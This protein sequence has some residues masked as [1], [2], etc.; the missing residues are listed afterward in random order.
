M[1]GAGRV[2][3]G[4]LQARDLIPDLERQLELGSRLVGAIAKGELRI[5][6]TT[7]TRGP[8][9]LESTRAASPPPSP[10]AWPSARAWSSLPGC[11]MAKLPVAP[12]SLAMVAVSAS[13]SP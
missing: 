12:L 8:P 10:T 5:A 2:L 13:P 4:D 1:D 6:L 7:P 3:A 11:N 9:P